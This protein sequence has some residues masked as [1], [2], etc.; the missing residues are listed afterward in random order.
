MVAITTRRHDVDLDPSLAKPVDGVGDEAA[1]EVELVP[2]P[3]RGEDDDLQSVVT[4]ETF[5]NP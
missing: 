2:R 1:G 3:R 5:M 4:M